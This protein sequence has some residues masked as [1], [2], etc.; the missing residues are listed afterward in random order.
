M[1]IS[2]RIHKGMAVTAAIIMLVVL[3]FGIFSNVITMV[4]TSKMS[5]IASGT[6]TVVNLVINAIV[7]ILVIIALFRG[8][9]D[10]TAA[11]FFLVITL[12]MVIT[13]VISGITN[14]IALLGI[15]L[16]R[17]NTN[18]PVLKCMITGS[19]IALVANLAAVGFRV[20]LALECFKPG[21]IS[22]CGAKALLIIL[23]IVNILLV[24]ASSIAQQ[25]YLMEDFG[26][27][28]FLMIAGLPA[29][30]TAVFSIYWILVGAAFAK[31]V[32]EKAPVEAPY[33]A[34]EN[35]IVY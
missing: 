27:A 9:K 15:A 2:N 33:T 3:T 6:A 18:D 22:G 13:G 16:L 12:A 28:R 4:T 1:K 8:K 11:I 5:G 17:M 29:V 34:Q 26:F 19:L 7:E 21:K 24:V 32:Y 25:S 10:I 31:P 23:P 14:I 30:L 35:E 20:L